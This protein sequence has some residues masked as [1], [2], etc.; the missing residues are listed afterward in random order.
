MTMAIDAHLDLQ[1]GSIKGESKEKGFEGQIQVLSWSW[2]VANQGSM[3]HGGGGGAGR[4]NFQDF[5]FTMVMCKASP[6]LFLHTATAQHIPE[7]ILTLRKGGQ[8][9]D[10][11]VFLVIKF[12]D[13][14]ISSYSTG[15]T[16]GGT[17]LPIESIAFNYSKV[18]V[19]YK[20]Q[21][22]KGVTKPAGKAG[23]DI[24]K[25]AKV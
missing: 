23:Y 15:G 16:D 13:L 22:E 1:K 2:G 4:A 24:K 9:G 19:E 12:T 3:S 6:D 11:Q 10:Q 21:D 18:E 14:L 20:E 25:N 5:H 8:K 7:A 17:G